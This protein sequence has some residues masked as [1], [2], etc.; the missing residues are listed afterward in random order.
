MALKAEIKILMQE[1]HSHRVSRVNIP[2]FAHD[3]LRTAPSGGRRNV[4][5]CQLM[6]WPATLMVRCYIDNVPEEQPNLIIHMWN[7]EIFCQ[8]QI[9]SS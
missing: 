5:P 4:C 8:I 6:S 2:A 7:P 9:C 1:D 3:I